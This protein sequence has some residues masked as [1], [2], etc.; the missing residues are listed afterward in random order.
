[1][2][3]TEIIR[4]KMPELDSLRGV[5]ILLVVFYHGFFWSNG[6]TG[7]SGIAKL[8]VSLTRLARCKSVFRTLW[9]S[10]NGNFG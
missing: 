4:A 1:M 2:D 7:L 8:F 10:D 5:A 9:I 3:S 6:L